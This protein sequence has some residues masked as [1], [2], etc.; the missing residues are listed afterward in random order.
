MTRRLGVALAVFLGATSAA[1][2]ERSERTHCSRRLAIMEARL[3][4]YEEAAEYASIHTAAREDV[5]HATDAPPA[6]LHPTLWLLDDGATLEGRPVTPETIGAEWDRLGANI[7][8]LEGMTG[9]TVAPDRGPPPSARA[10][11]V[12]APALMSS[13]RV[14]E[15]VAP[16][17]ERAKLYWLV[18]VERPQPSGQCTPYYVTAVSDADR[19]HR[20]SQQVSALGADCESLG[21]AWER[22]EASGEVGDPSASAA[23][24]SRGLR[25]CGCDVTDNAFHFLEEVQLGFLVDL[26]CENGLQRI[27]PGLGRVP[28]VMERL[29]S[30]PT[31]LVRDSI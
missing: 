3:K 20:V 15:I 7:E 10:L 5:P 17:E 1:G 31:A 6:G 16:L 11:L 14:L 19:N 13:A 4:I 21:R 27:P 8:G 9:R 23:A 18:Q 24:I 28:L 12:G 25:S 22:L 29:R 2:C 30:E 26:E